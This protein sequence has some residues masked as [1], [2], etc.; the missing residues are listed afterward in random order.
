MAD[1][2]TAALHVEL[3]AVDGSERCRQP[4]AVAAE[5]GGFPGLQRAQHLGGESFVDFVE[6]EI[7]QRE[8]GVFQHRG[9]GVGRRHQQSFL[10][11]REVHRPALAVAEPGLHR[12]IARTGPVFRG[13]KHGRGTIRQWRAVA[14]RQR[15]AACAVERG[16]QLRELL[17]RAVAAHV[18]VAGEALVLD[19]QVL[20]ETFLIRGRGLQMAVECELVLIRAADL[21]GLGHQLAALSH[22]QS[23]AWFDDARQHGL[24]VLAAQAEERLDPFERRAAPVRAQQ[25][26]LV[27]ARIH[28][29]RIADGVHAGCDAGI[30]LAECDLVADRDRRLQARAAGTL[31]V[32]AGRLRIEARRQNALAHQVEILRMLQH[33]A[34]DHV[35]ETLAVQL[36]AIDDAAQRSGQ[37]VL[38]AHIRIGAV[39][40]GEWNPGSTDHCDAPGLFSD[41]HTDSWRGHASGD[42]SGRNQLP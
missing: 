22:R 40:P 37:H 18:V 29:R 16:L 5:I 25:Q 33:G 26:L 42:R 13:E 14:G 21:P 3:R 23:R 30:D 27:R 8:S 19:D 39:G 9:H 2:N 31:H 41:E 32:E 15:T 4:E 6:V 24:E 10:A 1:G 12:Q 7:L 11:A 38:V 35:A 36:V 34:C 28:D 17:E 20:E